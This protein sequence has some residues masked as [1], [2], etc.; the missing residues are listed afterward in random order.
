MSVDQKL[1]APSF[2]LP[3]SRTGLLTAFEPGTRTLEAGFQ[4]APQFKPL[5]IDVVF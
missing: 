5:P 2:P 1:Y 4:V 3:V